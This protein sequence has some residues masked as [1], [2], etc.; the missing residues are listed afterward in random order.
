MSTL[1]AGAMFRKLLVVGGADRCRALITAALLTDK[2]PDDGAFTVNAAGI[3]TQ[4]QSPADPQAVALMRERGLSLNGEEQPTLT[5]E[6]GQAHDL[7]FVMEKGQKLWI[8]RRIP[9]LRGRIYTLGHWSDLV[10]NNPAGKDP[11]TY[12][13]VVERI[14]QAVDDWVKRLV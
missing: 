9:Q 14:E 4:D 6:L 2:L 11:Q 13:E 3:G 12:L 1:Q 5:L 7:I 8:E 10:V